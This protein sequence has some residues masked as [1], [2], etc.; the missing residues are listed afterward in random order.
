MLTFPHLARALAV[1]L[2]LSA[3]AAAQS[4]TFK[5]I[6]GLPPQ[7]G[8]E[9]GIGSDVRF[10]FPGYTVVD[11]SGN[12]YV[13]DTYNNTIRKITSAGVATTFAGRSGESGSADG[14]ATTARF[15]RPY[16]LAFDASGN[17]FVADYGNNLIRKITPAGVV[18]TIAGSPGV[19]G[20]S[21]GTGTTARFN[22][23]QGLAADA[24]GNVYVTDRLNHT[25]RKISTAGVVST[26]AGLAGFPGSTNAVGTNARFRLPAGIAID[27]AENLYV[28]DSGSA[29]IRKITAAGVVTT[30]AGGANLFGS[31]NA[32]GTAARFSNPQ[33]ITLDR[34]GNL[35]VADAGNNNVRKIAPNGTVT[36]LAGGNSTRGAIDGTGTSARFFFPIGISIDN[37]G[38]LYVADTNNHA[39]RKVS[40]AG[41]TSTLAGPL[42]N[43]WFTDGN[44]SAA[45]FYFP[46]GIVADS[47]GNVF[48]ADEVNA[49]IRRITPNGDVTTF[50]GSATG[51]LNN[52]DGTGN[53]AR[54]ISPRGLTV[55]S[56]D[57]LYVADFATDTIRKITPAA[58]VTTI[59][60]SFTSAS[61]STDGVGANARFFGPVAISADASGNLYVADSQHD[62]QNHAGWHGQH[63]RR[64][65]RGLR[66]HRWQRR[67]GALFL[68]AGRSGRPFR[69]RVCGGYL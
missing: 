40:T 13:S 67:R 45:R 9:D 1:T 49:T 55:D 65:R 28:T 32:V 62:S 14:P 29:I 2:L 47:K 43:T 56:A 35:Y 48:V 24:A 25:V 42:G 38:N 18:S 27:S 57:N 50:A 63:A 6:A 15:S 34:D 41:V 11:G 46:R 5:T 60:G 23:P 39:I 52:T 7:P 4:Y 58:V 53:A 64:H 8:S 51:A 59:A 22:G 69:Q 68:P 10:N 37:A 36:G 16:G 54:F 17:L 26:I 3:S 30:V 44:G 12:V 33:G 20:S 21:D 31:T 61:G 19:A 66:R